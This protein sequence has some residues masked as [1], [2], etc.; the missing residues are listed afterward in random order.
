MGAGIAQ[1]VLRTTRYGLDG[2]GFESRWGRD[3]PHP[4]T[5]APTPTQPPVQ[6]VP[7]LFSGVKAAG[8]WRWPPTPSSC[9]ARDG[10][11]YTSNSSQCLLGMSLD[12]FIFL[13]SKLKIFT[14]WI[15]GPKFSG[16]HSRM[17]YFCR[18]QNRSDGSLVFLNIHAAR[19]SETS[20]QTYL[21]L[22]KNS[23]YRL[24]CLHCDFEHNTKMHEVIK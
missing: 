8:A 1:S 16:F 13:L 21:T 17:T 20:E 23:E 14:A 11:S 24:K 2:P 9:E 22:R 12:S 5:T 4:S 10:W 18:N 19:S 15:F 3:F 7:W 6:W